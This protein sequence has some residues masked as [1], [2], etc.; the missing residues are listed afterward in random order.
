MPRGRMVSLTVRGHNLRVPEGTVVHSSTKVGNTIYVQTPNGPYTT[1]TGP[2]ISTTVPHG[3]YTG[4]T[5]TSSTGDYDYNTFRYF[6][7][8]DYLQLER[9][10]HEQQMLRE[11]QELRAR[12]LQ[13]INQ[14]NNLESPYIDLA[15]LHQ[16]WD[17]YYSL[18]EPKPIREHKLYKYN[19]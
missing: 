13:E 14:V 18:P 5:T 1:E 17:E 9:Q 6:Y 11:Q 12:R 19:K 2:H 3:T 8:G 16:L 7:T 10:A 15:R 4:N